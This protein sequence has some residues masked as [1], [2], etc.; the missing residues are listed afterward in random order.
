MVLQVS[1]STI[2][3][4]K[5][6]FLGTTDMKENNTDEEVIDGVIDTFP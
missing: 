2:L 1:Q 5:I 4:R 6:C 3:S